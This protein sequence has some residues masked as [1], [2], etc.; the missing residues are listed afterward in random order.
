M[1][2][3]AFWTTTSN[4]DWNDFWYNSEPIHPKETNNEYNELVDYQVQ[5]MKNNSPY[6]D[7]EWSDNLE[8]PFNTEA[9]RNYMKQTNTERAPFIPKKVSTEGRKF[10]S[11]T[12]TKERKSFDELYEQYHAM[13]LPKQ[14]ENLKQLGRELVERIDRIVDRLDVI[15]EEDK[16]D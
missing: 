11:E 16:K 2:D 8:P 13:S 4:K 9:Y 12:V 10:P 5:S 7:K 14:I 6:D 1:L 3:R 15:L